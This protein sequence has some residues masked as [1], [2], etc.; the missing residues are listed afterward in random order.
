MTTM[1]SSLA[2]KVIRRIHDLSV[3]AAGSLCQVWVGADPTWDMLSNALL[4]GIDDPLFNQTSDDASGQQVIATLRAAA[5]NAG[6]DDEADVY[7]S[8]IAWVGDHGSDAA[9]NAMDSAYAIK[10]MVEGIVRAHPDLNLQADG[11][12]QYLVAQVTAGRHRILHTDQG[13]SCSVFFSIHY[14]ARI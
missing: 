13:A 8:A 5:N 10:A 1:V 2:P 9:L 14:K 3:A 7:C 4:V 12:C 6:K 11:T